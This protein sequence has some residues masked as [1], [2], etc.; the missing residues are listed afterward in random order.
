MI[1]ADNQLKEKILKLMDTF[2][3]EVIEF[4][5][6]RSNSAFIFKWRFRYTNCIFVR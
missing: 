1:Y 5:E 4:K 2:E 6:A 3:N